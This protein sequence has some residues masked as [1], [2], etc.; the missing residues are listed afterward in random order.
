MY[1][2]FN[3]YKK[4]NNRD[5]KINCL[6]NINPTTQC[7]DLCVVWKNYLNSKTFV[8]F[9]TLSRS[10]DQFS[11]LSRITC[12]LLSTLIFTHESLKIT[13]LEYR[14][15]TRFNYNSLLTSINAWY[16]PK[17]PQCITCNKVNINNLKRILLL[18]TT[19]YSIPRKS[20]AC[21]DEKLQLNKA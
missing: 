11:H 15:C 20:Y 7:F 14:S 4:K 8:R 1:F 12:K 17:L 2:L 19:V 5:W 16:L 10:R 21:N 6:V 3:L 9:N 18:K 13:L